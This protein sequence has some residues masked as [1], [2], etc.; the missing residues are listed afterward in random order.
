MV[1]S[2]AVRATTN[3]PEDSDS[4]I[5]GL[6]GTY[7]STHDSGEVVRAFRPADLPPAPPIEWTGDRQ[8]RLER[9]TLALGRLDAVSTLLPDTALFLYS[10]TR[11]EIGR[12]HV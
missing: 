5:R 6:T 10:Y 2:L 9:A 12:A 1:I 8:R 4:M 3:D 7:T 11:R